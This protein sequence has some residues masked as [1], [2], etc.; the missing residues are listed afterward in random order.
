MVKLCC[1]IIGVAESAFT[2]DIALDKSVN[3]LKKKRLRRRSS[4]SVPADRLRLF[5]ANTKAKNLGEGQIEEKGKV[6]S[7]TGAWLSYD[8]DAAVELEEGITGQDIQTWINRN[9]IH[10]SLSIQDVLDDNGMPDPRSKKIHV[11]VVQR[12]MPDSTL[13]MS[14]RKE[15]E[16]AVREAIKL[17]D[18]RRSVYLVSTCKDWAAEELVENLGYENEPIYDVV[19]DFDCSIDPYPWQVDIAEDSEV[20]RKG[21]MQYFKENLHGFLHQGGDS[22]RVS[23]GIQRNLMYHLKDASQMKSLL[24]CNS[25]SLPFGL[26]GTSDLM[27]IGELAFKTNDVFASLHFIVDIKKDQCGAQERRELFLKLVLANLKSDVNGA[28]IGLLANLNDYWYFM[29]FTSDRKIARMK[30]SCPA[31]G[32]KVMKDFLPGTLDVGES[33]ERNPV[34]PMQIQFLSSPLPKRQKLIR[35]PP[36]DTSFAAEMLGQYELMSDVLSPEFLRD[37]RLEFELQLVKEMP[38]SVVCDNSPQH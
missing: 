31:N 10:A 36:V 38:Y 11:L 2:L 14:W 6:E 15:M 24:N 20:Q 33:S 7:D 3:D 8:S 28:P 23:A 17:F 13:P 5:L 35:P 4:T 27:I 19:E 1:V 25:S 16:E 12:E 32:F 18:E 29:W 9:P 34:Y 26:K 22:P 30:L 21:Y 37:R